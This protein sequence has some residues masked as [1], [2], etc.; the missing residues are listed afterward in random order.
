MITRQELASHQ[1]ALNGAQDRA[2]AA[3]SMIEEYDGQN[4]IDLPNWDTLRWIVSELVAAQT[5]TKLIALIHMEDAEKNIAAIDARN[6]KRR[7]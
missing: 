4:G 5:N 2:D 6:D 1:N 7:N 3:V